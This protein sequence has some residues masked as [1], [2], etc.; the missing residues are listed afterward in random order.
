MR[1]I[2]SYL[3]MKAARIPQL[4][5]TD[6]MPY[7]TSG[8]LAEAL[9]VRVEHICKA[10]SSLRRH[11]L[12]KLYPK[13]GPKYRNRK[14]GSLKLPEVTFEEIYDGISAEAK[15]IGSNPYRVINSPAGET[16]TR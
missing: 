2:Q 7:A 1:Q 14:Y 10:V 5:K 12:I 8:E 16:I 6:P 11:N 9:Q 15:M 13:P 3:D 4:G